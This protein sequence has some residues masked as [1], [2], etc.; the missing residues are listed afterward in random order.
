MLNRRTL[1]PISND[2]SV[3][4]RVATCQHR[5]AS[6][7][8][9]IPSPPHGLTLLEM[10][11]AL[12]LATILLVSTIAIFRAIGRT[13]KE[14]EKLAAGNDF[15]LT[16]VEEKLRLDLQNSTTMR[17]AENSIELRGPCHLSEET[18][19][20][21]SAAARVQW[22]LETIADRSWLVRIQT[23]E[24]SRTNIPP[25]RQLIAA[26]IQ[27]MAFYPSGKAEPAD[28]RTIDR[29]WRPVPLSILLQLKRQPN[30]TIPESSVAQT[31][32]RLLLTRAGAM[33]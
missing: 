20:P 29:E 8:V 28:G 31:R 5:S 2:G 27:S 23:E 14:A 10:I 11:A 18:R 6:P 22:N 24:S 9:V 12:A 1:Q 15:W 26:D 33:R 19:Q 13:D 4:A 32:T 7:P 25:W 21:T 16:E 17:L 3:Q 30:F